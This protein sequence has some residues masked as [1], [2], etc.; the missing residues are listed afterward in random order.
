M[1][2]HSTIF[3]SAIMCLGIATS[4]IGADDLVAKGKQFYQQGKYQ[5]AEQCL[6]S[7]I[8]LH[9]KDATAHY[10]LGN[11]YVALLKNSKAA[12]EYQTA[13]VLDPKG[14]VGEYS[15]KGIENLSNHVEEERRMAAPPPQPFST[16]RTDNASQHA[17]AEADQQERLTAE[18]DAKIAEIRNDAEQRIGRLQAEMRSNIEA[19][20]HAL[21]ARGRYYYDPADAN[22]E[23]K[24]QF[25]PQIDSIK[26]DTQKRIEELRSLYDRKLSH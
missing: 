5:K 9:P 24:K 15:R 25:Q 1:R 18:R 14:S 6:E 21:R 12:R 26:N 13:A 23:V 16:S 19:N 2:F 3:G 8:R 22:E 17:A 11:V 7:Q 4:A 20:G 10:L